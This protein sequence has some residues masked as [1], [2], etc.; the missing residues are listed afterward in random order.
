MHPENPT[1]S[2]CRLQASSGY[3]SCFMMLVCWHQ[4]TKQLF[5]G[6]ETADDWPQH[7]GKQTAKSVKTNCLFR[8]W[9]LIYVTGM[10]RLH[11]VYIWYILPE[12]KN[13]E[14][15]TKSMLTTFLV[16]SVKSTLT[17]WLVLPVVSVLNSEHIWCNLF[18]KIVQLFKTVLPYQKKTQECPVVLWKN[19]FYAENNLLVYL[20]ADTFTLYMCV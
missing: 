6:R 9:C 12:H 5:P 2:F 14:P 15:N 11:L 16:L 19:I 3:V 13:H 17:N 8:L 18:V 20:T 10:S 7:T 4:D 1:G